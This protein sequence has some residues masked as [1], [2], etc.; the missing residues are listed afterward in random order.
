MGELCVKVVQD[1]F[2]QPKKP[3]RFHYFV[4][5]LIAFCIC[6]VRSVKDKSSVAASKPQQS[7]RPTFGCKRS[8][9]P[10]RVH[11]M[12]PPHALQSTL[13]STPQSTLQTCRQGQ[14]TTRGVQEFVFKNMCEHVGND[15][16]CFL[17][18]LHQVWWPSQPFDS[19][20]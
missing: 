14:Q 4:H 10:Q 16:N 1:F 6:H 8:R 7:T 13:Q 3:W 17:N 20:D 5:R 11:S 9:N 2:R 19:V 15:S 12:D 18:H